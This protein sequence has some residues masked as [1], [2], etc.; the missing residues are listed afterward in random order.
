MGLM[1]RLEAWEDRLA[2]AVQMAFERPFEWSQHDCPTFAFGTRAALTG[3]D[4]TPAWRGTYTSL[5]G[6]LRVMR[7]LGWADYRAM[8]D[9]I[10]GPSRPTVLFGQRG[11]I[12]LGPLG[13]G[14][15]VV[16]GADVLGLSPNGPVRAP[17][18]GCSMVWRV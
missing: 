13:L 18:A 9:A 4:A 6:G 15:A 14:F 8:G 3:Q 2:E 10:L 1:T 11:D 12:A 7:R 16:L 5:R 17:L